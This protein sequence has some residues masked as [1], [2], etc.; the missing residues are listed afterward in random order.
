[1]T[2]WCQLQT[3]LYKPVHCWSHTIHRSTLSVGAYYHCLIGS[4]ISHICIRHGQSASITSYLDIYDKILVSFYNKSPHS[5]QVQEFCQH[6]F[7][8]QT[9]FGW[10]DQCEH[11]VYDSCVRIAGSHHRSNKVLDYL[12]ITGLYKW[13]SVPYSCWWALCPSARLIV[14]TIITKL[15]Q[16]PIKTSTIHIQSHHHRTNAANHMT[17]DLWQSVE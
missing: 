14:G 6:K 9:Q 12:V 3:N 1:M 17:G 13:G 10:S 7:W 15:I 11:F 5:Q 8:D 2:L 4:T 16:H